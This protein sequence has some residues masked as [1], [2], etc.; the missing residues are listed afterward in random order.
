M[1]DRVLNTSLHQEVKRRNFLSISLTRHLVIEI[2]SQ[3]ETVST[4]FREI[5]R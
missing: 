2:P 1:F 4:T 3:A 5:F